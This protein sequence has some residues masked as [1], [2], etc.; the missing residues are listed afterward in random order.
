[1]P[2]SAPPRFFWDERLDRAEIRCTHPIRR[3]PLPLNGKAAFR[4]FQAA[5]PPFINAQSAFI[6]GLS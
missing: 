6:R 3:Q 2:K 5:Q 1:V 4:F